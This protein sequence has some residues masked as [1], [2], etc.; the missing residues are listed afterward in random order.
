MN[1]S[2]FTRLPWTVQRL[3]VIAS[4]LLVGGYIAK[5]AVWQTVQKESIAKRD[6]AH[7]V[8]SENLEKAREGA[9]KFV[10]P[11]IEK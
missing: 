2:V 7:K 4:G 8:A 10:L 9:K 1:F 5:S 6:R 11:P 3:W